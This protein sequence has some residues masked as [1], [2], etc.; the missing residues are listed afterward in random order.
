MAASWEQIDVFPIIARIIE[1]QF[2]KNADFVEHDEITATLMADSEGAS[3]IAQALQES[4]E[5][6][7]AEWVAHN[8]VAWF[9]QRISVGTSD[10]QDRFDRLKIDDKWAYK[11]KAPSP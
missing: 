9:S 6:F 7:T 1:E 5:A 2:A 8:M 10:W 4:Q 11:P 3:L